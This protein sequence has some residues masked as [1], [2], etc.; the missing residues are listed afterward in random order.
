MGKAIGYA[1]VSTVQQAKEGVSLEAQEM[2]I[3]AWCT[4]QG[5]T[6][7]E[8]FVD[9]G[10]SG[11]RADNR[12]ELQRALAACK[13]GDVL[14]FYSLSRLSR[15]TRDVL[16]ILDRLRKQGADLASVTESMDT[17][18]SMGRFNLEIMSA[19]GTFER[20]VLAERTSMAI[21]HLQSQGRYI[22]GAR[23]TGFGIRRDGTLCPKPEEQR[24][25]QRAQEL[26]GSGM[27]LRTI[28]KTLL[29]EG[30][31]PRQGTTFHMESIRR[32]T[33][34]GSWRTTEPIQKEAV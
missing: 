24:L 5:L 23:P 1:R 10:L 19:V 30:F 25:I 33:R 16:K 29:V 32:W 27:G 31:V 14:V 6:L 3:Q 17:S 26:R 15:S 8:V 7:A 22:G 2:R 4:S 9:A 13:R 21:R 34:A 28:A 11:S 20:E 18:S 12:P